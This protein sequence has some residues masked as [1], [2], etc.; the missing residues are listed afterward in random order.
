MERMNRFVSG[1]IA[2]AAVGSVAALL[3]AP[4]PGKDTRHMVAT[5]AGEL[6]EKAGGYVGSLREKVR[7]GGNLEK[8]G[9]LTNGHA[10]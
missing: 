9:D 4:K 6:R 10:G 3:L 1:L 8:A 2:G 7:R 5:Q